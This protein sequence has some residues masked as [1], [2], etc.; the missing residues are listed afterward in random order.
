MS[1]NGIWSE[2]LRIRVVGPDGDVE[3]EWLGQPDGTWWPSVT[4]DP[5]HHDMV[6]LEEVLA[7]LRDALVGRRP[8]RTDRPLTA[9]PSR[10][11]VDRP[12]RIEGA[13]VDVAAT[14]DAIR[15]ERQ[16]NGG[17]GR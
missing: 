17:H 5:R 16:P 13:A 10:L 8:W 7:R 9:V 4:D 3:A 12:E 11:V 15:Y 14:P 6:G 1:G 2:G